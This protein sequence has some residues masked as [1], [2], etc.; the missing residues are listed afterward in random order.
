MKLQ[1]KRYSAEL[2]HAHWRDS[3]SGSLSYS[4]YTHA[5]QQVDWSGV[6]GVV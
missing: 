3:Y 1:P 4:A 2:A 5:L 6:A